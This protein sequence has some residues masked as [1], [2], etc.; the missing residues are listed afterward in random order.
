MGKEDVE[1]RIDLIVPSFG[2]RRALEFQI[3]LRAKQPRKIYAFALR[4]LTTRARG[5]R[6]YLEVVGARH[7]DAISLIAQRVARAIQTIARRFRD[8]G[9]HNLLG[10]RVSAKSAEIEKFDLVSLCGRRLLEAVKRFWEQVEE[11]RKAAAEVA[12]LRA[13]RSRQTISLLALCLLPLR[14]RHERPQFQARHYADTRAHFM[15]RR[16][17]V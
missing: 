10:V 12:A 8:F 15:P 5:V 16:H 11:Q 1:D 14:A 3:T 4:A 13:H 6:V 2:G 9:E 7:K 17:C